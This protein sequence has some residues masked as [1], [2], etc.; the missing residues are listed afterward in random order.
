LGITIFL[1]SVVLFT[2]LLF[3]SFLFTTAIRLESGKS[4]LTPS[5]CDHCFKKVGVIGLIP[6]IGY[7]FY[8]GRC[9][10]CG[11]EVSKLYPLTELVNALF[12]LLIFYKTGV[13]SIFI[14]QFV[15]WEVLFLIA[16]LDFRTHLIFPQ[17]VVVG[18]LFQITWLTLVDPI[19]LRDALIGLF[20]GA[21][22]FHFISYFYQLI[23]NRQGLGEGDATLLGLFGL[24]WGWQVLMPVIFY[25]AFTGIIGGGLLLLVKRRKLDSEIP[26]AP[27]LILG[28]FLVWYFPAL[29]FLNLF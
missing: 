17:P 16:L 10:H 25:G 12:V 19:L 21:G 27:W 9:R 2:G 1:W 13:S 23:R 7:L 28:G 14:Q 5:H 20:L 22:I 6:I 15:L 24:F 4:L 18:F 3:G 29:P 11:K 8:K 26:F